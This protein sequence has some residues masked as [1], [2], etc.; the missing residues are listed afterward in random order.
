MSPGRRNVRARS[1]ATRRWRAPMLLLAAS[2]TLV[3]APAR[4]ASLQQV[5][6]GWASGVPSYVS[7]YIYV[8]SQLASPPP[9]VVA[10]HFCG[11]SASAMFGE[12]SGIVSVADQRGFIMIFPQTSNNCWDV[13]ST[14]SLTHDGGGDT[15]AIAEMVTYTIAKYK[16]DAGRV[17]AMGISSGAMMTQALLGVYP[18]VFKA[19]AEFSGVADGCWAVDYTSSDQWSGPCAAGQVTMTAQQWGN[20]VRAQYPGYTGVRPRV[21]LWH[22]TAD[23]TINYNNLGE[24]IKEWTNVLGLSATPTTTE[25]PMTGYTEQLWSNSCGFTVLEAWTQAGGGHTTPVDPSAVISFFGLDETGP[26]MGASD[27]PDAGTA[28][29]SSSSAASSSSASSSSAASS[30]TSSSSTSSAAS[31]GSGGS[32]ASSGAT[33]GTGGSGS[34]AA[35]SG[36]GGSGDSSATNGNG[37]TSG[38]GS[39]DTTGDRSGAGCACR[40]APADE[41]SG[42]MLLAPIAAALG[43]LLRRRRRPHA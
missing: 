30:G 22:G 9:I 16:A 13:G 8:P 15:Q 35:S 17:Y 10:S 19:G 25:T 11:G 31:S 38:G 3:A 42:G 12:V 43:I 7:M 21:Q 34:S 36:V 26:D 23:A 41:R 18:D 27:C 39:T 20:L 4:A 29:S 32:T 33:S 1:T 14:K 2:G 37:S 28:S 6:S 24:A 40:M 5:T